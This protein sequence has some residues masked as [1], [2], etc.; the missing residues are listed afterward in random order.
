MS[1]VNKLDNFYDLRES[2]HLNNLC[3]NVYTMFLRSFCEIL[4]GG[5][6]VRHSSHPQ[7]A[8]HP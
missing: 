7:H 1:S 8:S 6:E 2:R 3:E 4:S 5:R